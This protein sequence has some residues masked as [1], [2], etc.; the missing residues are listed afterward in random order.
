[1]ACAA[2]GKKVVFAGGVGPN[3]VVSTLNV[4]DYDTDAFIQ[5]CC[6]GASASH[7]AAAADRRRARLAA[8]RR[9]RRVFAG[10]WR[11]CAALARRL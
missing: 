7:A 9:R 1:M 2:T 10:R 8:C 4:Y 3:G 11:Q 6:C 5:V